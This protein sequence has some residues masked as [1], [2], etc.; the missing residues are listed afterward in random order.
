MRAAKY[1]RGARSA[2]N[3]SLWPTDYKAFTVTW[4]NAYELTTRCRLRCFDGVRS[5]Q[6]KSRRI[7]AGRTQSYQILGSD[8]NLHVFLKCRFRNT[9]KSR[10][11]RY[12]RVKLWNIRRPIRL[13]RCLNVYRSTMSTTEALCSLRKHLWIELAARFSLRVSWEMFSGS[14][15]IEIN[16]IVVLR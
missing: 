7:A 9:C 8:S 11:H 13:R 12:A 10:A 6:R 2:L 15:A 1:H 4:S 5:R 3:G 16:R 14:T